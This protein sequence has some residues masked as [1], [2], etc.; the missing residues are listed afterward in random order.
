[1]KV[2]EVCSYIKSKWNKDW[3]ITL[4]VTIALLCSFFVPEQRNG[5]AKWFMNVVYMAAGGGGFI[6]MLYAIYVL[7]DKMKLDLFWEKNVFLHK[8]L[9]LV[10]LVPFTMTMLFVFPKILKKTDGEKNMTKLQSDFAK[11]LVFSENMYDKDIIDI[12]VKNVDSLFDNTYRHM[13]KLTGWKLD[14]TGCNFVK[15]VDVL[16]QDIVDKRTE[17]P[18]LFWSVYYHY[19][20]A[21]NQHIAA[22][23]NGRR[24]AAVISV[25]GYLLLNGL[26]VAVLIGWFDRRRE[27]WEKGM[28]RY[29][30]FKRKNHYVI[31]GGNDM[32][33]GIVKNLFE[34]EENKEKNK[35]KNRNKK[36]QSYIIIQTLRDVELFRRKLYSELSEEQQ[37]Y[38][39]IYYGNRT[40][41]TDI[42]DLELKKANAIY[43][44]GES[45]ADEG[46]NHDAF[47][48]DCL[49]LITDNLQ[50]PVNDEE[51]KKDVY[52]IFENQITFSSFQFS[53][54]SKEDKEKIN[55]MP[56]NYYEMWAQKT[57]A[58]PDPEHYIDDKKEEY[59]PLDA[60][61]MVDEKTKEEK[62]TY[63]S[64]ND[65]HYV[66][67]VIMGMTKMGVAMAIEAAHVAHYPNALT[68][69]GPRTRITFI[70][71]NADRE[72][73][74]F[75]NR[76]SDMF[77]LARWRYAEA[78]KF[79][80][81]V[82][83]ENNKGLYSDFNLE[84]TTW[85]DPLH[86]EN[87]I[88]P[89]KDMK[90]GVDGTQEGDEFF[91]DLEW[92][93]IKGDMSSFAVQQYLRECSDREKHPNKILTVAVCLDEP[94]QAIAAGLYMPDVVY[95]N[96]LQVLVYQ[97]FSDSILKYIAKSASAEE[98]GKNVRYKNVKPFGMLHDTFSSMCTDDYM[99]KLIDY[100]Y[101]YTNWEDK[102]GPNKKIYNKEN[103]EFELDI[104]KNVEDEWIEGRWNKTISEFDKGKS[105]CA[106]RWSSI[107]NANAIRT[108]LRSIGWRDK[109]ELH[110]DN[111]ELIITMAMTEHNRWN[112][113]QLLMHYSPL[114]KDELVKFEKGLCR[115]S[116]SDKE[117]GYSRKNNKDNLK[118]Q[119]RH[120]DICSFNRLRYVDP[121]V[122][123]Y[124]VSLSR[125]LP[126]IV[127]RY[128][129]KNRYD[130]DKKQ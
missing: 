79:N 18:S 29:D 90:L 126:Y 16:P 82:R 113:E 51:K 66:H 46:Q 123:I 76:Y 124:D 62:F 35:K 100:V 83:T 85:H 58:F 93:F 95:E 59:L 81:R 50:K 74:Y 117:C 71:E 108:K 32:V 116:C 105:G 101:N 121:G 97:R 36:K 75:M 56:L 17:E 42:E 37:E 30:R 109:V 129:N 68:S 60:I 57:F 11:E 61:R 8:V 94:H 38:I 88:S 70:D 87:S 49:S 119:M 4:L 69:K 122:D 1:M 31:I 118:Q 104:M 130:K 15:E 128:K 19:I 20:D 5:G 40:S 98:K 12:K 24:W 92:E 63:I 33:V 34:K 13:A 99:P 80:Q 41:V 64:K 72:S 120:I 44:V 125:S 25:L 45:V 78:D 111:K 48:M 54:I 89:Y 9:N 23:E 65:Q 103:D 110:K 3:L 112:V 114:R 10:L 2:K 6:Y 7:F 86:S 67:L 106:C 77:A 52:V 91:I 96:A 22:T 55:Y 14:S 115:F 21:G 47:N 53:D 73:G 127:E 84:D 102:E 107:Y 43:V 26:L 27:K 28:V 39:V